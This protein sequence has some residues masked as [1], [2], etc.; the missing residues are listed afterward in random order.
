VK[1]S[2]DFGIMFL[3][4]SHCVF[5]IFAHWAHG[6]PNLDKNGYKLNLQDDLDVF[7]ECTVY[8]VQ[9]TI[10]EKVKIIHLSKNLTPK[11]KRTKLLTDVYYRRV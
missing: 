3:K 11:F 4:K 2:Q 1:I 7:K 10:R 5:I 9:N 6:L 8:V